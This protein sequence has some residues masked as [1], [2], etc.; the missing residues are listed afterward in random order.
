M[1]ENEKPN[2]K[3]NMDSEKA[4]E[5]LK[6]PEASFAQLVLLLGTGAMQQLGLVPNPMNGKTQVDLQVAKFSIDLLGVL[7]EK[8][9]GNLSDKETQMLDDL[10]FDLRMRFVEATRDKDK[11]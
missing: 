8:T 11:K 3:G 4:D 5:N 10:L 2:T 7:Q 6:P 1:V 9:K